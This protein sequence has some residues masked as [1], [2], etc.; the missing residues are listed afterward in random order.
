MVLNH[1]CSNDL[2]T[3]TDARL[4]GT[5]SDRD[6]MTDP[7]KVGECVKTHLFEYAGSSEEVRRI[8]KERRFDDLVHVM[9]D[10]CY[11]KTIKC[12]PP[13]LVLGVMATGILHYGLTKSLIKSQRCITHRGVEL[14]I[15]IPD[16]RTLDT[17]PERALVICIL[18]TTDADLMRSQIREI[19]TI[20]AKNIWLVIPRT[21][22]DADQEDDATNCAEDVVVG[23]NNE[24][25]DKKRKFIISKD[26]GSFIHILTEIALFTSRNSV[27]SDRLRIVGI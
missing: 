8:I 13:G 11:D 10:A 25:F 20:R 15:V 6:D 26:G 22:I 2:E 5:R 18:K 19:D 12:G 7:D 24:S 9:V 23:A 16:V 17:Y 21:V 27:N 14:D 1:D 4:G 3:S